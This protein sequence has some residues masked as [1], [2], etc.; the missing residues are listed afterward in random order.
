MLLD[1]DN[2]H[3][4]SW[5]PVPFRRNA[6][7]SQIWASDRV[8]FQRHDPPETYI[9]DPFP[10]SLTWF[11]RAGRPLNDIKEVVAVTGNVI[12]FSTPV[13]ASYSLTRQ[14][15]LTRYTGS[16]VHVRG[17]G[18]EDLGLSGGAR[19]LP[20]SLYLSG[21]PAFFGNLPWPWVDP[22]G[23]T[24]LGVLPAKQ[25]TSIGSPIP[26]APTNLRIRIGQ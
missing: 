23:T 12:T 11:S 6:A 22:L 5:T 21:K 17:A 13:H 16:H 18:I 2:Y 14:A 20:A 8:V 1:E 3:A 10:G 19:A 9:D 24:K 25:R 4:A 15:Q 26:A 7:A